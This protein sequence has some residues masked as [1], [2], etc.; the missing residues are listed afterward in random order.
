LTEATSQTPSFSIVVPTRDRPA[1]LATCLASLRALDYPR[2]RYEVI[3]VDDGSSEDLEPVVRAAADDFALR[4]ERQESKGPAGARNHGARAA[5]GDYLAF[6]D[7]DCRPLPSWLRELAIRA[8]GAEVGVG[9]RVVAGLQENAY[10]IV[11][12]TVLTL[13]YDYYNKD[14]EAAR[15]FASNNLMFPAEAFR[16]LGGFDERFT[17]AEDRDLCDR[18][19]ASGRTLRYAPLAVVAHDRPQTLTAFATQFFR[20]GRGAFRFHAARRARGRGGLLAESRFH[21]GLPARVGKAIAAPD[22]PG[23][24][25][26]LALIGLWQLANA[27]GFVTEGTTQLLGRRGDA[28]SGT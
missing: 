19:I 22:S 12:H 2:E 21:L 1:K 14:P 13:V 7:D 5:Q 24:A 23:R 9:G 11:S 15:F 17:T 28:L 26:A 27:A 16:R 10:T 3:V 20:Y 8:D 6:T 25:P 18:W 4:L